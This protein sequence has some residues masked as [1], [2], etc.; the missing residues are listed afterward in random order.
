MPP[1]P[2]RR[3]IWSRREPPPAKEEPKDSCEES[4]ALVLYSDYAESVEWVNMCWRKVGCACLQEK[5]CVVRD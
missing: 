5:D 3:F 1:A 2:A 4:T